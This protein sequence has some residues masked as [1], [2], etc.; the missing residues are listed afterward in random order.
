MNAT[1]RT[2]VVIKTVTDSTGHVDVSVVT[3]ITDD[4]GGELRAHRI[5]DELNR[6]AR[7]DVME[8]YIVRT[9]GEP[10]GSIDE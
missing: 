1:Q 2:H 8:V 5:K 9:S 7:K 6:T 3:V 10:G 4:D